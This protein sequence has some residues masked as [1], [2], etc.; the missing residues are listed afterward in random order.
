MALFAAWRADIDAEPFAYAEH[1][2]LRY[3]RRPECVR[4]DHRIRLTFTP[5]PPTATG[6]RPPAPR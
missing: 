1:D 5:C 4:L 6:S 3:W 2:L